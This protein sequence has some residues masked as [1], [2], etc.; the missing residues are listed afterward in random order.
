[1]KRDVPAAVAFEYLYP[2]L[3]EQFGRSN[4]V[5]GFGVTAESNHRCVFEQQQH[6]PDEALLAQCDE[7]FLQAQARGVIKHA[8]L[9]NGDQILCHGLT[10]MNADVNRI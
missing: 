10:L 9:E 6:I 2:A 8:E 5:C 7:L 1:M 4:D 3:S